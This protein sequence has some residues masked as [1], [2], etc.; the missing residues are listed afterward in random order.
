MFRNIPKEF[1]INNMKKNKQKQTNKQ[2]KKKKIELK[3]VIKL[4]SVDF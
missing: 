4:F 2:T 3:G 1:T